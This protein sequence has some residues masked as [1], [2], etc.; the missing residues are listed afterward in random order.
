M[1]H[2]L[3]VDNVHLMVDMDDFD[4]DKLGTEKQNK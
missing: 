2:N 4:I 1:V 3:I